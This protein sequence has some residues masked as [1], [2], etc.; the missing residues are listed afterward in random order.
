MTARTVSGTEQEK[1]NYSRDLAAHTLRQWNIARQSLE[2][3]ARS[4]G[5][6]DN[7]RDYQSQGARWEQD[8]HDGCETSRQSQSS[9]GQIQ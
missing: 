4:D 8:T 6:A 3:K 1:Q 2:K 5:T 9:N 7:T